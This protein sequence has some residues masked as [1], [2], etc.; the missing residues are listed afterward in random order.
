MIFGGLQKSSL[1]DYPGKI[2]CVLFTTGCN[3]SCPYC[4]NPQLARGCMDD[5]TTLDEQTVYGFLERR[6]GFLEGVVISGGEPTLQS[7][8][9]AVCEKIKQMGYPVKLDTNGSRPQVIKRLLDDA[10]V[11]YIAMDIKTD[12]FSYNPL[13][14]KDFNPSSLLESIRLVMSATVE[15]EFKTTCIKPLV[16][17]TVVE[18]I[19][20]LISGAP[21]YALQQC[22]PAD[23]LSPEFFRQHD[24]CYNERE[25]MSLQSI[26]QPWVGECRVR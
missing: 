2:S 9:A 22:Q 25:L 5:A 7:D 6:K 8:L 4:H 13:I 24:R 10:L 12:P 17:A 14:Q 3:F 21:L 15:Y 26:A 20:R 19:S 16:D 18:N 11:D 1:I 23:V